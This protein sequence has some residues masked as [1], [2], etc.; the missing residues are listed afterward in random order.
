MTKVDIAAG[1]SY[2]LPS[3]QEMHGRFDALERKFSEQTRIELRGMKLMRFPTLS[4]QATGTTLVLPATASGYGLVGPESGFVWKIN[5]LTVATSG[6]DGGGVSS[7]G[8][9]SQPAVPASTVAQQNTNSYPVTVVISGGTA[10]ATFVNGIQVG[11]GDGTFI[12]PSGGAIS[13]T[14]SVAPTW[15]WSNASPSFATKVGAAVS[16]YTTSDESQ[17]QRNLIDSSLQVG[18]SFRPGTQGLYLMPSEGLSVVISSTVGNIYTLTGQVW[19]VPAE[20]MGK[21]AS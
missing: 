21:L 15:V 16:L 8:T 6:T 10:T 7:P 11:G 12:V 2:D 20:M 18:V 1:H 9:H 19:S 17:Q 13:V 14:Y 5:R 3:T 4:A